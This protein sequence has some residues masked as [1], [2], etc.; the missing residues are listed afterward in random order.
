MAST[1]DKKTN[2]ATPM[3]QALEEFAVEASIAK[4][5]GSETIDFIIDE[6]LQ[7]HG[8]NGFV[9]DDPAEGHH[10]EA[11]GNRIF[12]GTNE[13]NRPLIPRQVMKKARKGDLALVAAAEAVQGE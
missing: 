5:L 7:V 10:R 4:V 3:L 2:D 6:N 1:P 13:V 9:R 12:E 8:G 11:R